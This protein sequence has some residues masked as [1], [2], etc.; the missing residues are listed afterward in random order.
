MDAIDKITLPERRKEEGI[1]APNRLSKRYAKRAAKAIYKAS[2]LVP[3]QILCIKEGGIAL[4][5]APRGSHDRA[6]YIEC[7]NTSEIG[8]IVND[9]KRKKI[10]YN[11]D[12]KDF[13]FSRLVAAYIY[14]G[15]GG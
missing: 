15:G 6:M 5:Y 1:K 8:G 2:R 14:M 4:F 3:S 7:Y 12:V 13:D 11:E 10:I 9:N